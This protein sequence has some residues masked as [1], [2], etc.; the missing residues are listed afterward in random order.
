LPTRSK[1]QSMPNRSKPRSLPNNT[2]P[3]QPPIKK[4][5]TG[6]QSSQSTSENSLS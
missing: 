3:K 1:P 2:S 6:I 4:R 5:R